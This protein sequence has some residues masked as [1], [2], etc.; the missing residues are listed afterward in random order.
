MDLTGPRFFTMAFLSLFYSKRWLLPSVLPKEIAAEGNGVGFD[1]R[2]Y[3]REL[4]LS[5]GYPESS[6]SE[7]GADE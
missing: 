3:Y 4:E 1:K 6:S 5:A 2:D 7:L